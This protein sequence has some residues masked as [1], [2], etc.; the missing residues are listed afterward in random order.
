MAEGG[1]RSGVCA[2]AAWHR[3]RGGQLVTPRSLTVPM[4][5]GLRLMGLP[6]SR[7]AHVGVRRRADVACAA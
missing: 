5:S 1:T 3:S 4:A 6:A 7:R 2:A